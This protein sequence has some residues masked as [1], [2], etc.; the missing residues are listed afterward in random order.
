M[1]ESGNSL[2]L[3][4]FSASTF[5]SY[6]SKPTAC[7]LLES[8]ASI[9]SLK[10]VNLGEFNLL[11]ESSNDIVLALNKILAQVEAAS[12]NIGDL[13]SNEQLPFL[14]FAKYYTSLEI[15]YSCDELRNPE[16]YEEFF[17]CLSKIQV[18]DSLH[19][20][21]SF[22]LNSLEPSRATTVYR[23]TKDIR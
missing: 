13:K 22:N 6:L 18:V 23:T 9:N 12:I 4:T 14:R 2:R 3:E 11:A 1:A 15:I 16:I 7:Q 17:R 21:N 5:F 19:L 8:L 10:A 20:S